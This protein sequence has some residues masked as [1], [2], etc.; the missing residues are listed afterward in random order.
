MS[1]ALLEAIDRVIGLV[2]LAITVPMIGGALWFYPHCVRPSLAVAGARRAAFTVGFVRAARS[3]ALTRG[4][5]SESE[6]LEE[7]P[8]DAREPVLR[9]F[10]QDVRGGRR[11]FGAETPDQIIAGAERYPVFRVSS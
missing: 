4:G 5:G 1:V 2:T 9:A 3:A 8:V 10:L 11:Y 7:L 6:R